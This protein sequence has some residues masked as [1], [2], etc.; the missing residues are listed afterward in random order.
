MREGEGRPVDL[1]E[2]R[3]PVVD[4]AGGGLAAVEADLDG[5]H[6]GCLVLVHGVVIVERVDDLWQA[7]GEMR[8]G[9]G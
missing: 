4:K 6:L 7:V 2:G 9:G 5:V 1:K 8:E 3:L